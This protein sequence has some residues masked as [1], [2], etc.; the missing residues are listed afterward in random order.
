MAVKIPIVT[1]F[2]GKGL[3]QAQFQLNKVQG[4]FRNLGRNFA[5]AGAA[6]A[7]GLAV[8]GKGLKDAAESER[9]FAQTEAALKSTGTTANGTAKQIQALAQSLQKTTAVNDEAILSGANLLL[10][11]KNI[12]NQA[13]AGND[14]FDQTVAAT[15]DVARAM[16]TDASGEAIRLGKALNDPVKGI[17]ALTRVGIQFTDDQ[18]AMI[19]SLADSGDLLG[20][21]K[22][23]LAELN[24]QFGGS[25]QSYALTFAGQLD[26]LNNELDDLSEEIGFIVM[27]AVQG[28]VSEFRELIPVIGPQIKSA[29]ESVDWKGLVTSLVDIV[30]FL[31]ENAETIGKVVTAMFL[32][33]TAYNIGRVGMGLYNAGAAILNATLFATPAAGA[34]AAG[35]IGVATTALKL[36]RIA[37]LTTGI[38]AFV[39][40]LGFII[41]GMNE[42]DSTYRRTTPVVT[43]FSKDVLKTGQDAEWA[44]GKYGTMG[45]AAL[46]YA[47]SASG[48]NKIGFSGHTTNI[49]QI[50]NAWKKA[51]LAKANYAGSGVDTTS[52]KGILA[53]SGGGKVPTVTPP[54]LPSG[55]GGGTTKKKTLVEELAQQAKITKKQTALIKLGISE[56]LAQ[57]IVSGGLAEANKVLKDIREGEGKYAK[58]LQNIYKKTAEGKAELKK[59]LEETS[60]AFQ[61]A[62]R[63][64]GRSSRA[65]SDGAKSEE[66]AL[67]DREDA[68]KSFQERVKQT[69]ASIKDQIMGAFKLP[70]L[71]N[72]TES[73]IKNMNKLLAKTKSFSANVAKLSSMG[74]SPELLQQV[75]SQGPLAGAKLAQSLISGGAGALAAINA[76]YAEMAT[77]SSGIAQVGTSSMFSTA[78]QQNIYNIEVNGGLA[79]GPSI[80]QAIVEAITAYERTSGAVWQR[81]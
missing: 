55:G 40:A 23:I 8:I 76:G 74:L 58:R 75:I 77:L 42:V 73:I 78:P 35:G 28:L 30:T 9:V 4:N 60:D 50:E 48:V 47:T 31:L 13:G 71:G 52:L 11:F 54:T 49:N 79:T 45:A 10:T 53:A 62:G 34:A 41:E 15:L 33:N 81:R 56:G 17:S 18:K 70:Q 44:A 66:D 59:G 69:F 64:A 16:G 2:D 26:S 6:A 61:S 37:L 19:K 36:F 24:S 57:R 21:Q 38:G 25:A 22:I 32:L 29:I 20:A 7:A 39:V 72:S 80:G 12:Q 1:V 63:S 65:I 5:I 46:G 3:K 27:P 43:S 51:Q 67:K 14:I 68:Y